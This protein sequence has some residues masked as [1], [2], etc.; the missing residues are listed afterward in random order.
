MKKSIVWLS[1]AAASLG[2]AGCS[3]GEEA[4]ETEPAAAKKQGEKVEPNPWAKDGTPGSE[5]AEPPRK[6]KGKKGKDEVA[7]NPWAK[8]T[9]R[10]TA[11]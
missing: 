11:S 1:L 10:P 5:P 3:G 2:L 9:P 8:D 7:E 6:K 4:K